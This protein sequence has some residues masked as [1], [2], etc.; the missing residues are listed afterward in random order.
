MN[1]LLITQFP[2]PHGGGL[3]SHVEDLVLCLKD[4]EHKVEL[5]EGG[6]ITISTTHK[7]VQYFLSGGQKD[8]YRDRRLK[9][10][11][12]KLV[13]CAER[14][15]RNNSFDLI[16][17]HDAVAGYAAHL[18]L[19]RAG[20]QIPVIETIHGPATYESRMMLGWTIEQS[21]YLQR[22]FNIE[23]EA[24]VQADHLIAV[25]TGQ[26]DIAI[27]DFGIS[28]KKISVI[29]NCVSC[30]AIDSLIKDPPSVK[31]PQPYLLVPRRLVEKTGVRI[32]V[33]AL[34][35]LGPDTQLNLVI[36]GDG[37]LGNALKQLAKNLGL[38]SRVV[39]L[40]SIPRQEVLRLAKEAL[41]VVVPSIP[42]G[43]VIEATSIAVI[44]AMACG[45][46]VIASDIG[47]LAELI[48]HNQTGFLVPHSD[49]GA[50][51][52]T[53]LSLIRSPD[54]RNVVCRQARQYVLENLD[55]S[56][57]FDKV[58]CVYEAVLAS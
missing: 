21:K 24:F 28:K 17:C 12:A 14:L 57:W 50:L 22:L 54:Q 18:A 23:K 48:G 47:G 36:A 31:V 40:G 16:H 4:D 29:F 32:A 42:T 46:A 9:T 51:G 8:V 30:R 11:L 37:P 2:V 26:A 20:R 39:F 41:A 6:S 49:P 3:S 44:E 25:D 5:L 53:I 13:T 55:T 10:A 56:I 38:D 15:I 19:T 52:D 7:L 27:N 45:T 1:I 58:K 34:A 35:K 43:G 33:E